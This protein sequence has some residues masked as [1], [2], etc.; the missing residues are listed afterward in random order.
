VPA[1]V[2]TWRRLKAERPTEYGFGEQQL[3]MLGQA[4]LGEKRVDDAIAMFELNVEVCIPTR[5]MPGTTWARDCWPGD[6][7]AA[8]RHFEK[9]VALNPANTHGVEAQAGCAVP[10]GRRAL[11]ALPLFPPIRWVHR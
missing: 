2:A 4:L 8:I 7:T 5:P 1:A 9:S 3:G 11:P 10:D 6:T